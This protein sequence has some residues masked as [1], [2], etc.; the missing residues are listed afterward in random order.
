MNS[1]ELA[2]SISNNKTVIIVS[3]LCLLF[4]IYILYKV[5]K[6]TRNCKQII[7]SRNKDDLNNEVYTFQDIIKSN[8][9]YDSSNNRDYTLKDFYIKTS[10]NSYASGN[11]SNDYVNECAIQNCASY[12]VRAI[13][14]Q[15]YSVN[16]E[17]VIA[18][19]STNNN[20]Y[21]ESY[22]HIPL[23]TALTHIKKYF[24]DKNSIQFGDN[25]YKVNG[26]DHPLFIFL[27]IHYSSNTDKN[28][29]QYN[30]LV[31]GRV[32]YDKQYTIE[33]K[34]LEF[35]NKIYDIFMAI[36]EA[37]QFNQTQVRNDYL[38]SIDTEQRHSIISNLKMKDLKEKILLF[39]SLNG[40]PN[41]SVI[42]QSKLHYITDLYENDQDIRGY[43]YD[44]VVDGNETSL[45]QYMN[46]SKLSYCFPE[47]SNHSHND[48][49]VNAMAYGIQFVGMNFQK[50]DNQLQL[51]N[52]FFIN[53]HNINSNNNNQNNLT[54]PY[55]KK[56]DTM[57]K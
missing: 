32:V 8:Y 13:D 50:N 24:I 35:Y 42:K 16:G 52:G 26:S 21:K 55:I 22:N 19:S 38:G 28:I 37:K 29:K 33:T 39:I 27:R 25:N 31:N 56:P 49:F 30:S 12:G 18:I 23:R 14:L 53:N 44:E 20:F 34:Q 2:T 54:S 5:N 4:F 1:F 36:F 7:N 40:E 17:P 46:K 41:T 3:C 51:Y 43:R 6:R 47:F 10:Y 57:L 45:N 15:I 48:D 11:F 9:F